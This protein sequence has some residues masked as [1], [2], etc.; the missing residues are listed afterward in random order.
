M[1]HNN[2]QWRFKYFTTDCCI[3][4]IEFSYKSDYA[5]KLRDD[6]KHLT[7]IRFSRIEVPK[8]TDKRTREFQQRQAVLNFACKCQDQHWW[9]SGRIL[10]C[11]AGDRG[12]IPRQCNFFTFFPQ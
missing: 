5:T 12:S 4:S 1:L 3:Y 11:H 8:T 7:K 2:K 6:S 9:F 10:A